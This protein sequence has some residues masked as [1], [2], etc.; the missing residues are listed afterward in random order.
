MDQLKT[1][2]V[3]QPF[4]GMKFLLVHA[5]NKKEAKKMVNEGFGKVEGLDFDVTWIGKAKYAR[6]DK[7][8]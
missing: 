8:E 7:R 3:H 6:E 4:R 5:K 2:V 1:Y